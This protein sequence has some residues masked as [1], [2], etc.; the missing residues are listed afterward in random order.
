MYDGMRESTYIIGRATP[1]KADACEFIAQSPDSDINNPSSSSNN[2][3]HKLIYLFSPVAACKSA[4][5]PPANAYV[6]A[7]DCDLTATLDTDG[8]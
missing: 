2:I 8:S 1:D 5:A 4:N 3:L 7:D 6:R